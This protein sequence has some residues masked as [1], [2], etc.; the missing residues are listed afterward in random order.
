MLESAFIFGTFMFMLMG[1]MDFGR[2]L[3]IHQ[4]LVER[5]RNAARWGA[6]SFN[7]PQL[8]PKIVNMVLYNQ[9]DA[10]T[11]G[12]T[13]IFGLT[14]AMVD[15][16]YVCDNNLQSP[17]FE[18]VVTLSGYQFQMLS[19]Y[20]AGNKIGKDIVAASPTEYTTTDAAPPCS[21]S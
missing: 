12:S 5:A 21:A 14:A 18:V 9:P 10:P 8:A 11:D 13:P 1:V 15:V 17:S 19:P 16:R 20:V 2:Y 3:Y 6:M 4:H 7:D